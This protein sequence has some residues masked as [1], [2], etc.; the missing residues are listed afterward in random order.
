MNTNVGRQDRKQFK[1]FVHSPFRISSGKVTVEVDKLGRS[2]I[3][4]EHGEDEYTEIQCSAALINN[5]SKI[6]KSIE[7]MGVKI[8]IDR[9]KIRM[10]QHNPDD[11]SYDEIT[12]NSE[13]IINS[14]KVLISTREVIFKDEP[15]KGEDDD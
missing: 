4:E 6:L 9:E 1:H 7:K 12:M 13:L 3:T 2:T 8:E 11:D 10:I 15:F 5:L 14:S